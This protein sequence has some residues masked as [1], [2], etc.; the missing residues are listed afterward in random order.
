[1]TQKP[2]RLDIFASWPNLWPWDAVKSTKA[3]IGRGE[4]R[5]VERRGGFIL[6]LR[7]PLL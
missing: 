1:M 5:K 4:A 2:K 3:G 7:F 6:A